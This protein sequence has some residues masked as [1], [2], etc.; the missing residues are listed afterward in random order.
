MAAYS[1]EIGGTWFNSG[2]EAQIGLGGKRGIGAD[3]RL[4][5][6]QPRVGRAPRQEGCV[7]HQLRD[8][9]R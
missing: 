2:T 8:L 7:K 5:T 1:G 3:L 9:R 4:L 6:K